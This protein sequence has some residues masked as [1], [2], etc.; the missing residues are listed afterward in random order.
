[1]ALGVQKVDGVFEI[2]DTFEEGGPIVKLYQNGKI[3]LWLIPQY[4]GEEQFIDE[5]K[6]VQDAFE[7]AKQYA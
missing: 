7:H 1:M 3:E 6:S 4:G 2:Y 5:F